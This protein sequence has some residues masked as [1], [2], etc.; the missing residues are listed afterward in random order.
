MV[1]DTGRCGPYS[2]VLAT[3]VDVKPTATPTKRVLRLLQYRYESLCAYKAASA[4]AP[5]SEN[6]ATTLHD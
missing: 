1:D 6:V 4:S 5:S 2:L 3:V